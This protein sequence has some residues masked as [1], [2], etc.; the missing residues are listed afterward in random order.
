MY[1]VYR[2]AHIY[3]YTHIYTLYRVQ[4]MSFVLMSKLICKEAKELIHG[5]T[6]S[7][8]SFLQLY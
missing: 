7:K 3:M 8:W 4:F 5:L 6:L 1:S 2:Y